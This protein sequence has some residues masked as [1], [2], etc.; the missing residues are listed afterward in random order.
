MFD[1]SE[2]LHSFPTK[3]ANFRIVLCLLLDMK[4]KLHIES[5]QK[6]SVP[7]L[8]FDIQSGLLVLTNKT[9][10]IDD[11]HNQMC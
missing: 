11:F 8:N 3:N 1:M 2:L 4:A 5:G 7:C 9:P 6:I 10:I